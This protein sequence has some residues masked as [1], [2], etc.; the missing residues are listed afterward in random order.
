MVRKENDMEGA[1]ADKAK[2][3]LGLRKGGLAR[4]YGLCRSSL[5][6]F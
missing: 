2:V 5:R 3:D 4:V 1:F 6:H